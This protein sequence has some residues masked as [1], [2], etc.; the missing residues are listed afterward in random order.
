LNNLDIWTYQ[1]AA[2]AGSSTTL[3]VKNVG[4]RLL[5]ANSMGLAIRADDEIFVENHSTSAIS[6]VGKVSKV[7]S[8]LIPTSPLT[9]TESG[10]TSLGDTTIGVSADPTAHYIDGDILY[11]TIGGY[12]RIVG[13][14]EGSSAGPHQITLYAPG[15]L[16]AVSAGVTLKR[17]RT[18]IT[19][20]ANNVAAVAAGNY[21]RVGIGSVIQDDDDAIL[22]RTWLYPF[23]P[24]GFRNGD[25]VW[26]NMTMN[27]PHAV[28]GLFCK[29]RGVLNEG[30]VWTGFNGG[31]GALAAS[32]PRESIPIENFLIG[33]NCL[34]T[35]INFAQHVNKTVELNYESMG[36]T[37]AQAPKI[38]YVDPYQSA[39]DNARVLLYDTGHDREFIAFH[40]LHMQVQSSAST[41]YIGEP[42]MFSTIDGTYDLPLSMTTISGGNPSQYSTQLDVAN[43][44]PSENKWHRST[45]CECGSLSGTSRHCMEIN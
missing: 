44:Y 41:P 10:G 3:N 39:Q 42:R 5:H 20:D 24:G 21:L 25:T 6:Y 40:D 26:M 17:G 15:A 36:L 1:I 29:S 30:Q 33:D 45:T 9:L 12:D 2:G 7:E 4:S 19:L 43:G 8:Y 27:N 34:E 22:N 38:A 11:A 16:T 31:K 13:V 35:A 14:V 23:A 32:R 18:T 28:E 37:A